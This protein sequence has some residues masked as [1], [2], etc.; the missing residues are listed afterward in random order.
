MYLIVVLLES[1]ISLGVRFYT[2]N[3]A[4]FSSR[5][6]IPSAT[7]SLENKFLLK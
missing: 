4:K 7:L 6:T 1:I 2:D 3:L 5:S